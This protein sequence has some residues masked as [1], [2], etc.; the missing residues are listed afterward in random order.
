MLLSKCLFEDYLFMNFFLGIA[1]PI[2]MKFDIYIKNI[3]NIQFHNYI[4]KIHV[5]KLYMGWGLYL[6][7]RFLLVWVEGVLTT[8]VGLLIHID[9][10]RTPINP[11]LPTPRHH[12]MSR[13]REDIMEPALFFFFLI[14]HSWDIKVSRILF[15]WQVSI[16]LCMPPL[17]S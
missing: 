3:K 2:W 9:Q 13:I 12:G 16:N 15:T 10:A 14:I 7:L 4:F 11:L 8:L 17:P 1:H 5:I 6:T